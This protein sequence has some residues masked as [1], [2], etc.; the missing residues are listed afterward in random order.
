MIVA[1]GTWRALLGHLDEVRR[2]A[3]PSAETVHRVRSSASRL[4]AFLDLGGRR[5]LRDDLRWLRR[6]AAPV[7]DA[8]VTLARGVPAPLASWLVSQ[9]AEGCA[10]LRGALRRDRFAALCGAM[11]ELKPLAE[12]DARDGLRRIER[13]VR[14]RGAVVTDDASPERIHRLRRALRRLRNAREWMGVSSPDLQP[15]L[16][17]LGELNDTCTVLRLAEFCPARSDLGAF[18]EET[19]SRVTRDRVRALDAWRR[20]HPSWNAS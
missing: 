7:R 16:D 15:A 6:R 4:T 12:S 5:A 3:D 18:V 9:R 14:R 17:A 1:D 10:D 2:D 11:E 13:R 20:V 8:D 19:V